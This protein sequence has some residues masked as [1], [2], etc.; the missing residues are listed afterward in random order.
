MLKFEQ[1]QLSKITDNACDGVLSSGVE[2]SV[3]AFIARTGACSRL[4]SN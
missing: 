4:R 2:K 3:Y 1:L